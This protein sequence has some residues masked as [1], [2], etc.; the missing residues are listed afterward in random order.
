[1]NIAV[2]ERLWAALVD[3]QSV[4]VNPPDLTFPG[5]NILGKEGRAFVQGLFVVSSKS[6]LVHAVV[7][8]LRMGG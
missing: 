1:M 3:A 7:N 6:E 4:F 8:P 2:D 5:I